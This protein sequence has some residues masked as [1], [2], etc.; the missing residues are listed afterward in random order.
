[1]LM[2]HGTRLRSEAEMG[3]LLANSGFKLR[4]TLSTRSTLRL[5]ESQPA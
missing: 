2:A 1:M 3:E 4:R 5:F